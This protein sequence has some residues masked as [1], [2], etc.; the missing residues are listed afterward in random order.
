MKRIKW[1]VRSIILVILFIPGFVFAEGTDRFYID[2]TILD[3][4]DIAV[5]EAISLTGEYNGSYRDIVY[6]DPYAYRF[7]GIYSN[8]AG[9]T[10]IYNGT[11]IKDLKVYRIDKAD[12]L[13]IEDL[14]KKKDEFRLVEEAENGDSGV[15]T[16]SSREDGLYLKMFMPSS[17]N[18]V[19]YLEYTITDAVVLHDDVAELYWN[20]LG[21]E[22]TEE[23]DDFQVLVHLPGDG[24]SD[25]RVWTH[26]PLSGENKIVDAKTVWFKDTHVS[27]YE[28]E[29]IRLMFSLGLVPNGGKYSHVLGRKNILKYEQ[30]MADDA[31]NYRE[32]H[33]LEAVNEASTKVLE[34]EEDMTI[35][36]YAYALDAVS[37]LPDDTEEKEGFLNRIYATQKIVNQQWKEQVEDDIY[38]FRKYPSEYQLDQLKTL[39]GLGI[40]REAAY[41]YYQV[42]PEL[43]T[44]LMDVWKQELLE[45]T[46]ILGIPLLIIFLF[47]LKMYLS[48]WKQRRTFKQRYYRDFPTE[49]APGEIEYLVY[50]KVTVN[51]FSAT[52]L[53]LIRKKVIRASEIGDGKK[54]DIRLY[55]ENVDYVP[56]LAESKVLD[57]LFQT[58]GKMRECT[59]NDLKKYGTKSQ[60]KAR[61]IQ[62]AIRDFSTLSEQAVERKEYFSDKPKKTWAKTTFVVIIAFFEFML[63]FFALRHFPKWYLYL[64]YQGVLFGVVI[65]YFIA[66]H[67]YYKRT[68]RGAEVYS[69]WLAHRRFLKGFGRFPEKDLPEVSLW[70]RY[71]VTATVFRLAKRVQ[72]RMELQMTSITTDSNYLSSYALINYNLSRSITRSVSSSYS[73][74]RSTISS[75][76][77]GGSYSSGGGF[78]GGSSFGGGSG[79]GGGGGGRF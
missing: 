16:L 10:D 48:D 53:D 28:A 71:L 31:N 51:S 49:D 65:F 30:M 72:K 37:A 1:I 61:S 29:T 7:T 66:L 26:G 50:H 60:A 12:F 22:Y 17:K 36:N 8:F 33:R 68:E 75:H 38:W 15:Y 79:G 3:N 64:L 35:Y 18:S 70:E 9:N 57:L 21:E 69:M 39:I 59:L 13:H 4:G 73:S 14:S 45:T 47:A 67:R 44:I 55:L 5:K 56:S 43:E 40:D 11:G 76:S 77:S 34:L 78:G 46:V 58:V 20:V 6:Q 19:F 2:L 63:I 27:S 25:L 42:I 54:K 52:I 24:D 32:N 41:Q 74:A 62:R 23:I